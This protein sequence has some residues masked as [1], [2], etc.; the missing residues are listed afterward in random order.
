MIDPDTGREDALAGLK[1]TRTIQQRCPAAV[2]VLSAHESPALLRQATEAGVSGY[3]VKPVR[4][5]D[6]DRMLT[7]AQARFDELQKL[8]WMADNLEHLN[9]EMREAS[10]RAKT[11]SGLLIVCAWCR[12]VRDDPGKWL[13][14]EIYVRQ[15][16]AVTFTHGICLECRERMF[17]G[18]RP[19][20]S[21]S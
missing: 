16:L 17:L 21:N 7:I 14:F 13:E 4:D 6:L 8:R 2:V 19:V 10:A 11:L 1:A 5:Q 20:V 12:R 18:T 15:H 9:A 3:L